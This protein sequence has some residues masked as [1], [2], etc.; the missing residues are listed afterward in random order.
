MVKHKHDK[1]NDIKNEFYLHF[2]GNEWFKG[3]GL[4]RVDKLNWVIIALVNEKF[5]DEIPDSWK[6]LI[7]RKMMTI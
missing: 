7:V 1:M 2:K 5:K 4:Y 3:A 6:G